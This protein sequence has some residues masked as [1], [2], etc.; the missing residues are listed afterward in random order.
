MSALSELLASH[1]HLDSDQ[2]GHLQRL[3][4]EWQLF[5]DLSFADLL[6]WVPVSGTSGDSTEFL[7]AAQCRPTTGPTAYLY[8]QVGDRISGSKAGP[9][10]IALEESRI[11]RESDPD[12]EGDTPIRREAIPILFAGRP[13]AVLGRDSN[14]TSVRSPS[15]LELAYLQSAADLASMIAAGAFPGPATDREEAAGPRVGDG[16]IRVDDSGAVLYASPNASSAFRRLGFNG[17]LLSTPLS[18]AVAELARDPFD[19]ADLDEMLTEALS[20]HHP[21]SREIDGGGAIVQ[22]RAI[23]LYPRGESLGALVLLQDVTELRRRDRQIMSKDATIR[24][25][26]HRVKNN[27]Q[28]VAALLRLQSRRL[29]NPEARTALE[30]SMRRVSSIALVHETLSSAIDEEVD[31]DEVV[32]RLL[33]MLVDVTGAAGRVQVSRIGSFGELPAELATPLVMVLTELVGNAVEHGFADGRGG[34]VGVSGIRSRGTLTVTVADD[35]AGLPEDFSLDRTD[36]L[37]LQIVRT[38]VDAELDAVLEL[39]QRE[40]GKSG[41]AATVRIPLSR[42]DRGSLA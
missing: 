42:K 16:M 13:V 5:A 14:L 40:D 18:E 22:F 4:A 25:I 33:D 19:A 35:G 26:H 17:N 7:C 10:R 24:E 38:L 12:W 39:T 31:F 37:G 21:F 27:L 30:E 8:D 20:G 29:A 2:T 9:L 15:Q 11:F 32:D 3:V 23:P 6:L 1:T 36:R 28:T 34:W 41:T